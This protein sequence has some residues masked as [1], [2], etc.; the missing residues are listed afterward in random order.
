MS[1]LEVELLDALA[2]ELGLLPGRRWE[3]AGQ[4]AE[5]IWHGR[6][7]WWCFAEIEDGDVLLGPNDGRG[8]HRFPL[9]DPRLMDQLRQRVGL[10]PL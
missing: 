5:H 7:G 3:G 10:T 1:E 9:A 8:W 2:A 6:G 4:A